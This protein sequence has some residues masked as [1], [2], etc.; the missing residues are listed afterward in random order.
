MRYHR[1][2]NLIDYVFRTIRIKLNYEHVN[3]PDM[4]KRTDNHANDHPLNYLNALNDAR[5]NEDM[6]FDTGY[7][8][9]IKAIEGVLLK[10]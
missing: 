10:K 7:H 1:A 5:Y 4:K 3:F 6:Y 2:A 9:R 8:M